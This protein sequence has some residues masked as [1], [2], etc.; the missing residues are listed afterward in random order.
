MYENLYNHHWA[1]VLHYHIKLDIYSPTALNV[2]P[3]QLAF[4]ETFTLIHVISFKLTYI[5]ELTV[6]TSSLFYTGDYML[7]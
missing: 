2:L 6:T 7:S 4:S 3:D 5:G 1:I